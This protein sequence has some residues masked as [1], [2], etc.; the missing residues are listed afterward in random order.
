MS[1]A[2]RNQVHGDP[3]TCSVIPVLPR[4]W[5]IHK[6]SEGK[7]EKSLWDT[8]P[9][10][11]RGWVSLG[12][13]VGWLHAFCRCLRSLSIIRRTRRPVSLMPEQTREYMSSDGKAIN[14]QTKTKWHPQDSATGF[15]SGRWSLRDLRPGWRCLPQTDHPGV[16]PQRPGMRAWE[17]QL[18]GESK[19]WT[20]TQTEAKDG[21]WVS[22]KGA[23][24]EG[25]E[26]RSKTGGKAPATSTP[27][28][29][30]PIM[31]KHWHFF[32]TARGALLF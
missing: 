22:E 28:L 20:S 15:T 13:W 11:R 12:L 18:T 1:W 2:L 9:F 7:K 4:W 19:D 29:A 17:L 14:P 16:L 3:P 5:P 31:G 24:V 30:L 27:E 23:A 32:P 21:C 10:F 25:R 26:L 8:V 6:T